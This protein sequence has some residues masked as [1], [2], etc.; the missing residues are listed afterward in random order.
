[1]KDINGLLAKFI[2]FPLV[3]YVST[4]LFPLLD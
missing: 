3:I 4:L 1:M 2:L